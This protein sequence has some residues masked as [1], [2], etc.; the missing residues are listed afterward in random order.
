MKI[1]HLA[2]AL[3]LTL[4]ACASSDTYLAQCSGNLECARSAASAADTATAGNVAAGI[5]AVA[6]GVLVVGALLLGA[7]AAPSQTYFVPVRCNAW[8]CW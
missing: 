4:S 6:L 2:L 8:G 1:P 7:G 3:A 5:G